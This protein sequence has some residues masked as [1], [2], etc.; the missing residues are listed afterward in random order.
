MHIS[1]RMGK[2]QRAH[3]PQ[4]D[5]SSC[6]LE[7]IAQAIQAYHLKGFAYLSVSIPIRLVVVQIGQSIDCGFLRKPKFLGNRSFGGVD[8]NIPELLW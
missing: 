1:E 5:P 6:P 3:I 8:N 2:V 4:A 7:G